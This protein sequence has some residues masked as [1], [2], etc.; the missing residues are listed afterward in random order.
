[1]PVGVYLLGGSQ[2][3]PTGGSY[4]LNMKLTRNVIKT[5]D[6]YYKPH[7]NATWARRSKPSGK[8]SSGGT[9]ARKIGINRT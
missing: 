7:S 8:N 5:T 6:M 3:R 9:S 2:G 1:M 4:L